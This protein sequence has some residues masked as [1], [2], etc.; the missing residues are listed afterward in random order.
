MLDDD[1]TDPARLDFDI[2]FDVPE[3]ALEHA[4]AVSDGQA[5]AIGYCTHWYHCN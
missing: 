2:L 4:A 3:D 5:V 1:E